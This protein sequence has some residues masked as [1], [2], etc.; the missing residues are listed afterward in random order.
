[1]RKALAMV[2]LLSSI[3]C[4][5]R[6]ALATDTSLEVSSDSPVEF[7]LTDPQGDRA[8]FD[9]V[10]KTSSDLFGHYYTEVYCDELTFSAC[11][12]PFKTLDR[13]GSMPGTYTLNVIGTGSGDFRVEVTV[14]N[15]A[16]NEFSHLFEGVTAPGVS[17]RFTFQG[18]AIFFAAFA[19]EVKIS[20]A[21]K[22]FEV[23]G[24]FTLGPGGTLSPVTQPVSI[25][26]GSS[27]VTIPARSFKETPQGVFA[28]KGAIRGLNLCTTTPNNS[29]QCLSRQI[30]PNKY[31]E[32]TFTP[33]GR[34][35][36]T[37]K[38]VGTGLTYL[39]DANPVE[40]RLAVGN[41]GGNAEVNADFAR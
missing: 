6:S 31:L 19:P 24:T 7:N 39:P 18:G 15:E 22:T 32:S 10:T 3:L 36:Y 41:N 8:G 9:P 28:F 16:G 38:I 35:G 21:S 26:V 29:T 17:S 33:T 37:F 20:I 4:Y 12:M 23:S 34:S 11:H 2:L 1:M 13:V 5:H 14:R 25:Q 30:E 40:V 27:L